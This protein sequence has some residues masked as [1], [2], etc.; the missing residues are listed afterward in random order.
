MSESNIRRLPVYL[1]LDCSSSM[2][3]PPM[4]AVREGLS[5][6]LCDLKA[7]PQ[8]LETAWLSVIVFDNDARQLMPLTELT[9]FQ[10]PKLEANGM[11]A[12]GAALYLVDDCI[13]KE[14]RKSSETVKGDYRPLIFLMTDGEP[15]D[16][17]EE[18]AAKLKARRHNVIACAAGPGANTEVLKKITEA[19][20]LLG[21][22]EPES[23]KAF[24]R[25][26]SASV[27]T[28]SR[29]LMQKPS[30]GTPV[31]IPPPPSGFTIVP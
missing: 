28:T 8:A 27:K 11:T 29:N 22:M 23:L 21:T 30:G 6:L 2:A 17:F 26:V 14:V 20:I 16:S 10:E 19:V 24:F 9:A 31:N 13:E 1:V 3:G 5:M 25:W 18:A 7:N 4:K 12:L 15:S